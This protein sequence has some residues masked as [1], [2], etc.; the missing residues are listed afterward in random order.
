MSEKYKADYQDSKFSLQYR[1]R[2]ST[3][4]IKNSTETIFLIQLFIV[5]IIFVVIYTKGNICMSM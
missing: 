1:Y 2:D 3:Y 4:R 5:I